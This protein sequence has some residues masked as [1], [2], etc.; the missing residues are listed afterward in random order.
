MRSLWLNTHCSRRRCRQDPVRRTCGSVKSFGDADN[1]LIERF[2]ALCFCIC[3]MCAH[4]RKRYCALGADVSHHASCRAAVVPT[5]IAPSLVALSPLVF[6]VVCCSYEFVIMAFRRNFHAGR[7]VSYVFLPD[8]YTYPC[9]C[10]HAYTYVYIDAHEQ[11]LQL[12]LLLL[13]AR[14]CRDADSYQIS[15][16]A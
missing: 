10:M 9:V 11:I 14:A 6:D 12:D 3:A 13:G 5:G 7:M 8:T 16:C 1:I 15:C 4:H 2:H